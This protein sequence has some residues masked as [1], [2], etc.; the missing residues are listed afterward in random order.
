[1][2]GDYFSSSSAFLVIIVLAWR[3]FFPSTLV[4]FYSD[5]IKHTHSEF[6]QVQNFTLRPRKFTQ[7]YLEW[8]SY[9]FTHTHTEWIAVSWSNRALGI[10][11]RDLEAPEGWWFPWIDRS[12]RVVSWSNPHHRGGVWT[13][14]RIF[15]FFFILRMDSLRYKKKRTRS[16]ICMY[17]MYR[18]LT[19]WHPQSFETALLVWT[20]IESSTC[21]S[22]QC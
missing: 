6:I 16:L 2:S 13:S 15:L 1:M 9:S 12:W 17:V 14:P 21:W 10:R 22:L 20:I 7:S 19:R 3:H 5:V 8:R 4:F 18:D 11:G